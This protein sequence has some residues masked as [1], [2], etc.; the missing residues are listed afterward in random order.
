MRLA[1]LAALSTALVP[2]LGQS[3]VR[4]DDKADPSAPRVVATL[5]GHTNAVVAVAFSPDGRK[6]ATGSDDK[7]VR[8]W[9]VKTGE[10]L[11]RIVN[12]SEA[13][14]VAFAPDGQTLAVGGRDGKVRIYAAV[15]GERVG[16]VD[17]NGSASAVRYAGG[18]KYL[19]VAG[20]ETREIGVWEV[21]TGKL[22]A[23]CKH[24]EW[25]RTIAVAADGKKFASADGSG[26]ILVWDVET[27]T[28][29]DSLAAHDGSVNALAFVGSD[30][31]LS[32]GAD[33]TVVL[34]DLKTGNPVKP[35]MEGPQVK[36]GGVTQVAAVRGG[37]IARAEGGGLRS[38]RRGEAKP[39]E[40]RKGFEGPIFYGIG[41]VY[42]EGSA[43]TPDG[44][45]LAVADK[46]DNKPVV[47]LYDLTPV[48]PATEVELR[49]R[50]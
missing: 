4:G 12:Q 48:L 28:Q 3:G 34:W 50:D 40:I 27:G 26:N 42:F 32:G 23:T 6:V 29:L 37:V 7:T 21:G 8:I 49:I 22:R 5:K 13:Y 18:G 16:M 24:P 47:W 43:F 35:V 17:T 9:D 1:L 31:L 46:H 39:A 25:V 10:R 38:W 19:V 45:V 2:V 33:Q 30:R 11:E 44:A 20:I 36:N 41:G 15:G 14:A